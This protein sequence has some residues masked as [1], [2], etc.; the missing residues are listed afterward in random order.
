MRLV[1]VFCD[2]TIYTMHLMTI[3]Y[4]PNNLVFFGMCVLTI[5]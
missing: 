2:Y 3:S 4:Y 1:S 5:R